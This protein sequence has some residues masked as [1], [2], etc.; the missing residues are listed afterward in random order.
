MVPYDAGDHFEQI[1]LFSL[2]IDES[3]DSS[4]IAQ[5]LVFVRDIDDNFNVSEELAGM[6][7]MQFRSTPTSAPPK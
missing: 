4:D 5:L 1:F 2:P 3:T 6:Q 7:S